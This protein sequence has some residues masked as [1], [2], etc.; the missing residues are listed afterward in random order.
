MLSVLLKKKSSFINQI[1][2]CQV[3]LPGLYKFSFEDVVWQALP[4]L[5]IWVQ[6][7]LLPGSIQLLL[8]II[9]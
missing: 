5:V 4:I 7:A 1:T 6:Y 2:M 8:F 3:L 9:M